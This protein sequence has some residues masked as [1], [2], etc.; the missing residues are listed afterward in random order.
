MEKVLLGIDI[1][2]TFI[3]YAQFDTNYQIIKKWKVQSI[4]HNTAEKFYDYLCSNIKELDKVEKIGVSAPGLID[5]DSN[6]NSLAA[7]N[8]VIMYG[9]N[10]NEEIGKRTNKQVMSINDAKSAGLCEFKLGNARGIKS[11]A[12]LIIGTGVGGCLCDQF[13]VVNGTD[14]FA[15]EFHQI[16]MINQTTGKLEKMGDLA[17]ITGLLEIY[18]AKNDQT[19]KVLYGK[20]VCQEYLAGNTI[21][22]QAIDEW[23]GNVVAMLILITVFYNPE[24][25]CLGGGISEEDWLIE[26]V[27]QYYQKSCAE[28]LENAAITTRIDRCKYNNDANLLG[29][30][31]NTDMNKI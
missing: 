1:G 18:N 25:I 26:K 12:F 27:D 5:A 15:G 29:A 2:G 22:E 17:S 13:G 28:Y 4:R 21:A 30:I 10:I 24:V 7:P 31:I 6:V 9:T 19:A 20:D 11:S 14:G 3:K 16:P 23:I 8:V